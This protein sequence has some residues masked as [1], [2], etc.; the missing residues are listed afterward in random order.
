MSYPRLVIA[1]TH[2]GVGKTTV[3]LALLSAFRAQG[4]TVQPFKVGPDFIDP[5]HHQLA[6]GRESRNVDGWM[7]GPVVNRRIFQEAASGADLSIIE[8][9]M[10]LF[11]GSSPVN[12]T[13]ST[14]DMA[15]QLHAPILLVVDGSA[16]ARSA[17]AMVYG[18]ANFDSSLNIVGVIFNRLNSEGHYLLLKEAVEQGTRIPVVGY[19]RADLDVTIPDRHL[20]LRTAMEGS[21]TELYARLGQLASTTIDLVCVEQLAQAGSEMFVTNSG[22]AAED[23]R[24]LTR[25]VRVG[26]AFDQAFCFYYPENLQLLEKAGGELVRFSPMKDSSLPDVDLVYLGGGYPEIYAEVLQRNSAMRQSIQAFAARGGVVYAECGGLMYLAKTLRDFDGSD[27]DMVGVIPAETAMSRT[28]MTL[29]YRELTVTRGGPLG[30]EGVRIRGHEFHYSTLHPKGDLD[31][32]GH[33][34][35][36]QGR[37]RGGDGITVG[38]VIALYTHLHFSSHPHVPAALVEAARGEAAMRGNRR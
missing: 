35:D 33:L 28:T 19:L 20:G 25:S 2:S 12:A 1:G 30:D 26:V 18:Y 36:A 22:I 14:A 13:G 11:D 37:D 6:C 23:P 27:Y 7:L 15:H 5:G 3:T 10:G 32:L 31:Y 29:G 4:R 24:P 21:E 17:A 9:M 38:N 16:M 34:T 8:G